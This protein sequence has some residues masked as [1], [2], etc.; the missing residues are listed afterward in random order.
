V[1]DVFIHLVITL[2][3][4]G[5]EMGPGRRSCG[6]VCVKSMMVDGGL[7]SIPP[8]RYTAISSPNCF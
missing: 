8:G 4:S 5:N 2:M 6:G 1:V 7:F 3:I